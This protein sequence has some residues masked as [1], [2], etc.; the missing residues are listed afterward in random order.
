MAGGSCGGDFNLVLNK[1]PIIAHHFILSTVDFHYQNEPL[2]KEDL[3]A[4]WACLHAW[5]QLDETAAPGER[6]YAFFNSGHDSGASQP[7][8]HAQFIPLSPDRH[9][10]GDDVP[11]T[12]DVWSHPVVPF[13]H[14]VIRLRPETLSPERL[15]QA[16][17]TLLERCRS[18]L[19]VGSGEW[20][21][22]MG[23]TE[24]WIMLAPRTRDNGGKEG[25][26]INGTVLA[27]E[28]VGAPVLQR[29]TTSTYFPTDGEEERRPG[30]FLRGWS[31]GSIERNRSAFAARRKGGKAV[32]QAA[33]GLILL[34]CVGCAYSE[35]CILGSRAF[36]S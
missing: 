34:R 12:D 27:G 22:N 5:R 32:R 1:Y 11:D 2:R 31:G 19:G 10:F 30:P 8:R 29:L 20:S 15:Y 9:V 3:A 26:T 33:E 25:L 28:M 36:Q 23:M 6:L 13:T 21:Y 17:G 7:H 18:A 14:Y 24:R 35:L 16:Y 4:V